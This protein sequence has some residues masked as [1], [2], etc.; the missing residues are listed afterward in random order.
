[1]PLPVALLS[2]SPSVSVEI[3]SLVLTIHA[4]SARPTGPMSLP[5]CQ[6]GPR[7]T[8]SLLTAYPLK[9][10]VGTGVGALW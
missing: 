5:P 3:E 9:S 4:T 1:M 10:L 7:T 6:H 8:Y 2:S